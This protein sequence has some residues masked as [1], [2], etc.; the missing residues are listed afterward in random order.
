MNLRGK[1]WAGKASEERYYLEGR[2][3]EKKRNRSFGRT[4]IIAD[5]GKLVK[6]GDWTSLRNKQKKKKNTTMMIMKIM[7]EKVMIIKMMKRNMEKKEE[8]EEGE[9]EEKKEE[10]EGER[11]F[12]LRS[13]APCTNAV[14]LF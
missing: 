5:P 4:K 3:W 8:E 9:E 13:S 10:E 12:P 11:E 14:K 2:M 7:K 1:Y 6:T